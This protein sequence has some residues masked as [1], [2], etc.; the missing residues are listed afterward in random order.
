MIFAFIK[1]TPRHPGTHLAAGVARTQD[2][3]KKILLASLAFAC[4]SLC[5]L[6]AQ[7]S[8]KEDAKGGTEASPATHSGA[9]NGK[10]IGKGSPIVQKRGS[11][12]DEIS[13]PGATAEESKKQEAAQPAQKPK[14]LTKPKQ[15]DAPKE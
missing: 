14:E 12:G 3:M 7:T 5:G 2:A 6:Q 4:L 9:R 8:P 11:A 10:G 13:A 15:E 1:I